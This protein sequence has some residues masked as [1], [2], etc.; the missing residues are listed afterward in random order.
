[1]LLKWHG[2]RPG[3]Q[4]V[5]DRG[6]VA[7]IVC[8][9][10]S[11]L[12]DGDAICERHPVE[13]VRLTT[14]PVLVPYMGSPALVQLD[15]APT[16]EYANGGSGPRMWPSPPHADYSNATRALVQATWPGIAFELPNRGDEI[17]ADRLAHEMVYG[18]GRIAF[19]TS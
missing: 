1:M 4:V 3:N 9:A 5:F 12:K 13:R 15:G 10:E 6:L 8:P 18:P 19:G 14:L 11:W 2:L 16:R 17:L 7:S